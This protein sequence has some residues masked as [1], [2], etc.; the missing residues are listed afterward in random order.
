MGEYDA[1][2][3]VWF[4]GISA[5][6][7]STNSIAAT[8]EWHWRFAS[9]HSLNSLLLFVSSVP[10][11]LFSA[12]ASYDSHLAGVLPPFIIALSN[13]IDKLVKTRLAR[14]GSDLTKDV[15]DETVTALRCI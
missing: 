5:H 3:Q 8:A 13:R 9:H 14:G 15:P 12:F 6:Y 2:Q 4:T 11:W 7:A 1:D 10:L